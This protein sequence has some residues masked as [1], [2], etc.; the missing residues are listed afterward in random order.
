MRNLLLV[1]VL[2]LGIATLA[3]GAS[4]A[5]RPDPTVAQL[6]ALSGSAFDV[7]YFQTLVPVDE[8]AVEVAM[9]AT[10]TADHTVLL[11]WNQRIIERKN[12]QVRQMLALLHEAGAAPTHRNVGVATAPVKRMRGL[13]GAALEQAYIPFMVA[14]FDRD[15][16]WANMA[17][18]KANRPAVRAFAQEIIKVESQEAAMLRGWLKKWYGKSV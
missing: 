10:L 12:G 9:A 11:Q 14:H 1:S 3:T 7:A 15:V 16:A 18:K 8:E 5:P 2:V 4:P 17:M 6:S 13:S